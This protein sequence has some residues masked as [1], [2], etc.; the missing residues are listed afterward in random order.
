LWRER[1]GWYSDVDY[2]VPDWWL[3]WLSISIRMTTFVCSL[4][5]VLENKYIYM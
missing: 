2:G 4:L 5:S 3:F 1:F